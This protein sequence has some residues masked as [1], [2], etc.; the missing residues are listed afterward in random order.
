MTTGRRL[1]VISYAF[2]PM[3]SAGANRWDAMARHLRLLGHEVTVL[4]TSA[5]GQLRDAEEEQHIHRASDLATN[6][7]LRRA[8]RRGRPL[9]PSDVPTNDRQGSGVEKPLPLVL[10][11]LLVP[12]PLVALWLPQAWRL[13]RKLV[14]ERDIECTITSSPC[15]SVH[16]LGLMLRGRRT[17]WIADFRDGWLFEPLRSPFPTRAQRTLDRWLERRTVQGADRVVAV[18]QPI[19]DD[20]NRRFRIDAAY[21]TNGFDP[22]RYRS[23][24]DVSFPTLPAGT[25]KLLH[26]GKLTTVANRDPSGLFRALRRLRERE[27]QLAARIRLILAGRLDTH[28]AS[29]IEV[30]GVNENIVLLGELQHAESIALQRKADVLLLL[31]SAEGRE[32]TGKLFEYLSSG[33]P[34]LALAGTTVERIVAETRTGTTVAPDDVDGIYEQLRRLASGE[35]PY[36]APQALKA[37]VYPA[38][39]RRMSLEIEK[40]IARR[41]GR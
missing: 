15:E 6:Q 24:P 20:F 12:D 37:Y 18:T 23:L 25:V 35:P 5:F 2:P 40:A 19:A 14:A 9:S 3:P 28:D 41:S 7:W 34:I 4:T 29:V 30:S 26:T 32:A 22:I 39:A 31:A 10:Q 36:H 17:S 8:L 11:R 1:L 21:I 33:R 27:P 38:P 16:L 13:A